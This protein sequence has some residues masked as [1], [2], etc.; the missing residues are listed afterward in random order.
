MKTHC[1]WIRLKM[2][3]VTIASAAL[4]FPRPA[5]RQS[6]DLVCGLHPGDVQKCQGVGTDGGGSRRGGGQSDDE[7]EEAEE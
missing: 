3:E 7:E 5:G 2:E 4:T 6:S 1:V